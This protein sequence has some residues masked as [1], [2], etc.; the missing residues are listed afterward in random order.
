[1]KL[2][3]QAGE[4][5][6]HLSA[7]SSETAP[8]DQLSIRERVVDEACDDGTGTLLMRIGPRPDDEPRRL[9]RACC[10]FRQPAQRLELVGGKPHRELLDRVD[11]LV[12]CDE[13]HRVAVDPGRHLDEMRISPFRDRLIPRE[14]E[15]VRIPWTDVELR[16]RHAGDDRPLL[17][18]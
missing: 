16:Y 12:E 18:L 4:G 1:M 3:E 15:E 5:I 17:E 7:A 13:H 14:V 6:E 10:A 2:D 9:S 11:P 8:G